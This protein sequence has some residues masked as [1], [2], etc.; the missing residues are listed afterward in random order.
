MDNG[1]KRLIDMTRDEL[2]QLLTMTISSFIGDLKQNNENN[3][4]KDELVPRLVVAR[5]FSVTATSLD[6]WVRF[7]EFPKPIKIGR[8]LFFRRADLKNFIAK[9]GKNE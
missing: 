8:K 4:S 2:L 7:T 5:E 1:N 6:K 3:N 9:G